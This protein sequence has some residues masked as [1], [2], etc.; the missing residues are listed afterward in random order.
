MEN[1]PPNALVARDEWSAAEKSSNA[2]RP[3]KSARRSPTEDRS[4]LRQRYRTNGGSATKTSTAG[5]SA[6]GCPSADVYLFGHF[7]GWQRTR[8]RLDATARGLERLLSRRHVR[9]TA[10]CTIALQD[11]RARRE[12]LATA[13]R[14]Y[15]TVVQDER[16][17]ISRRV[18]APQRF[19]GRARGVS[20]PRRATARRSSTRPCGMAQAREAWAPSPSSPG[21]S[22]PRSA[23][24]YNTVQLMAVA[25]HPYYGRS[26]TPC[27][28]SSPPPRGA[29]RPRS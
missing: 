25:E 15:R 16:R 28:V 12:R 18:P 5:G 17:K 29:A 10:R 9:P 7:N 20:R 22:C 8:L 11:P 6:S 2:P 1:S 21:A 3:T 24:G 4:R 27:R 14:P 13:S 19:D 26:A 23:S